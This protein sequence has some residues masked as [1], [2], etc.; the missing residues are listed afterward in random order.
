[1]NKFLIVLIALTITA[2]T[3]SEDSYETY[4]DTLPTVELTHTDDAISV[5]AKTMGISA[6]DVSSVHWVVAE[7]NKPGDTEE[8]AGGVTLQ[9]NI[10]VQWINPEWKS[11]SSLDGPSISSSKFAHEMAHCALWLTTGDGDAGHTNQAWWGDA[12]MVNKATHDLEA[13][14]L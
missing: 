9:C 1:M 4:L 13:A 7:I 5:V 12:G 8:S 2:C 14:K 11:G 6:Q 10:W 3:S